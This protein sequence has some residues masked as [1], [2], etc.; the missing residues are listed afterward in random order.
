MRAA[1]AAAQDSNSSQQGKSKKGRVS[2][3]KLVCVGDSYTG[4]SAL[5]RRWCEG[6]FITKYRPT[7]GVD[8]LIKQQK[9]GAKE[10]YDLRVNIWDLSGVND[11]MEVRTEFYKDSQGV[12]LCYDCTNR[13]SFESLDRWVAEIKEHGN[14]QGLPTVVVANK[15]DSGTNR[16]VSDQEGRAWAASNGS[17]YCECSSFTGQ[18][19]SALF[20]LLLARVAASILS[21]PEEL[22]ILC[23]KAAPSMAQPQLPEQPA[24]SG[25][26]FMYLRESFKR[27]S[28]DGDRDRDSTGVMIQVA[29]EV[30]L[31]RILAAKNDYDVLKLDRNVT[32]QAVK[33]AY[34]KLA[35]AVHPDKNKLENAAAAFQKI[36]NA[37]AAI[38]Q[39]L[40]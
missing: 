35:V 15:A 17:L 37:Y 7:V 25:S 9:Y 6:T 8:H 1:K 22:K 26:G 32:L 40:A 36:N 20:D 24:V 13:A 21:L 33:G 31:A 34:R 18:G 14:G 4:K 12:L 2:R 5:I 29:D 10:E 11:F 19:V 27:G 28:F 3:L 23:S 30:E 39:K 38:S 16:K